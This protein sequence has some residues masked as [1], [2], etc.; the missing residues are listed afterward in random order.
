MHPICFFFCGGQSGEREN[1]KKEGKVGHSVNV[2][3]VRILFG[4]ALHC[5]RQNIDG[6]L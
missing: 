5:Q 1:G 3:S 2:R 4:L 6:E